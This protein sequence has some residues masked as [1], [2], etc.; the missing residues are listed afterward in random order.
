MRLRMVRQR[1]G[2]RQLALTGR[3]AATLVVT[4]ILGACASPAGDSPLPVRPTA[5]KA[6]PASTSPR[7]PTPPSVGE[8][9]AV[10]SESPPY[11]A[12]TQLMTPTQ[13]LLPF[14]LAITFT[15]GWTGCGLHYKELGDPGGVMMIGTWIVEN[16]YKDPCRWRISLP[17]SAVG[18]SVEDLVRELDGQE[19]TEAAEASDISI[20]GY[21][22][23]FIR[24][25]VPVGLDT[26]DCDQDQIAEFRFWNGPGDAVW[27]LGA[28][29]APGLIGEVWAVDVE[30]TRVVIQSASF[31]DAGEDRRVEMREIVGSIDFMP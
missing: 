13:S 29:D 1:Q 27:W 9:I 14:P 21:D 4:V 28:A 7:T 2:R 10:C 20:D 17:T 16:V 31:S 3:A 15:A 22:G 6:T 30:G 18:P 25:E 8:S 23:Q 11:G 5:S 26:S 19:G 24:L 12:G